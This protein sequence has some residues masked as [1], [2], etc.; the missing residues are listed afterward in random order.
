M[1]FHQREGTMQVVVYVLKVIEMRK[2]ALDRITK[3][4]TD[5][6]CVACLKSLEGEKRVIRGC[7]YR[8]QQATLKAIRE[9]KFTE[10]QRVQSGKFLQ[11]ITGRPI[12]NPVSLEA[13][14]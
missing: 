1:L 14:E 12:S 3:C 9:G 13:A 10:E 11:K 5:N 8:C 2:A 4:K 6:L 7:H